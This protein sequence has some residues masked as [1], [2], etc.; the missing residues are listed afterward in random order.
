VLAL[1][2]GKLGEKKSA[3]GLIE[4]GIGAKAGET[5]PASFAAARL[6][7]D[8]ASRC[9]ACG[10]ASTSCPGSKA[11]APIG[12]RKKGCSVSS[13]KTG[14]RRRVRTASQ[15][16]GPIS[17]TFIPTSVFDNPALLR[18]NPEYLA[19]LLSLPLP[20]RERLLGG[21][22]KIRP[23]A[24]LFQAGVV[25]HGRRGPADLDVVH[26]WDLAANRVGAKG[27]A[28]DV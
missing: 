7:R 22:W 4:P 18:V 26:Y 28:G 24:A 9:R 19:W 21:N 10:P 12:N 8:P 25:C 27:T 20:K 15:P 6:G 3:P 14:L 13:T 2:G 5:P 16:I 11:L 17:V 23:A 1:S